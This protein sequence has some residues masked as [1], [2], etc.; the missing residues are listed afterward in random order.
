MMLT[1]SFAIFC[2]LHLQME[3]SSY[4]FDPSLV[5]SSNELDENLMLRP[6]NRNDFKKGS[7]LH[8]TDF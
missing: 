3:S 8:K 4:L 6:L 5:R 1:P 7:Y 2:I